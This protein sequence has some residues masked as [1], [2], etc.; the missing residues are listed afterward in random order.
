MRTIG[1]TDVGRF[2]I[3]LEVANNDDVV[4][5]RLGLLDPARVRRVTIPGVVD[6]GPA[7]LVLP[8]AVADQLALRRSAKVKV[9]YADA[10]RATRQTA[11]GAHVTLLRREWDFTAIIEPKRQDALIGAIIL[12]DLDLLV[13]CQNQRLIPR[14]PQM[15]MYECD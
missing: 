9:R 3:R 2:S 5:A 7:R 11:E 12:E 6:S 14:D 13:D 15:A 8:K 4:Q 10:R 1:G